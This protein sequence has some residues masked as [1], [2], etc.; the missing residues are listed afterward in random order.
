MWVTKSSGK[1]FSWIKLDK[2]FDWKA[3]V[4]PIL[5]KDADGNCPEWCPA[6]HFGYLASGR[7]SHGRESH[8]DT[9]LY[10][11]LVIIYTKYTGRRQNDFKVHA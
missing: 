1:M 11:S 7:I 2:G 3:N 4:G 5:P 6:T 8:S 10:I 9:T